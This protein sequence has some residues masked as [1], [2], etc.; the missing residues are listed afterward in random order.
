[1][2]LCLPRQSG[3]APYTVYYLQ[4]AVAQFNLQ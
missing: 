2:T 3:R 1:M 4:D